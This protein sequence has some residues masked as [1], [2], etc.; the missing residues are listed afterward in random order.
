MRMA[1]GLVSRH[2][3]ELHEVTGRVGRDC[4]GRG[5]GRV[6]K[7]GLEAGAGREGAGRDG[8]KLVIG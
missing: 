6:E 7:V 5:R 4:C 2:K 1:P 3:K 8:M